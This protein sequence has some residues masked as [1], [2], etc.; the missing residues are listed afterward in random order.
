MINDPFD[1][2]FIRWRG[3]RGVYDK[4]VP[5]QPWEK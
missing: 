4:A 1:L 3:M 2:L 5:R